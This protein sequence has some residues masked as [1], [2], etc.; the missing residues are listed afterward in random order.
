MGM[1]NKINAMI[2]EAKSLYLIHIHYSVFMMD[3]MILLSQ[4]NEKKSLYPIF[5]LIQTT[6]CSKMRLLTYQHFSALCMKVFIKI[7]FRV[8]VKARENGKCVG[9][10]MG[11]PNL[12]SDFVHSC[13][14]GEYLKL[15][16]FASSFK[17]SYSLP[18]EEFP[19]A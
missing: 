13:Y 7:F 17:F 10:E 19:N 4:K 12:F 8:S 15:L 11:T 14:W 6:V 1:L 9:N 16:V 2:M 3:Q 5:F 18:S